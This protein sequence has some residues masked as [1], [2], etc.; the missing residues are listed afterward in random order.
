MRVG[1]RVANQ[2]H[3][4]IP[5][6]THKHGEKANSTSKRK[7]TIPPRSAIDGSS[8]PS[9]WLTQ[10]RTCALV[11][12]GR[13]ASATTPA[14]RT[15][16]KSSSAILSKFASHLSQTRT[17]KADNDT[18]SAPRDGH[19]TS[20]APNS[21]RNGNGRESR[22]QQQSAK[23]M[24]SGR[25]SHK[26]RT[27]LRMWAGTCGFGSS[28]SD[29]SSARSS[30]RHVIAV[31]RE[32]HQD[33]KTREERSIHRKSML[34]EVCCSNGNDAQR[35]QHA[36]TTKPDTTRMTTSVLKKVQRLSNAPGGF[37]CHLPT[38]WIAP[39][40]LLRTRASNTE[41]MAAN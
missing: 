13:R 17:T 22:R 28:A 9:D 27:A 16:A 38:R 4:Q 34:G 40:L 23:R 41:T 12:R 6:K 33:S 7:H 5:A 18:Q 39:Q 25:K 15:S 32:K 11:A 8:K 1:A 19:V 37:L 10:G 31:A 29:S 14:R 30:G 35:T 36:G 26:R 2:R 21:S 24:R 3:Q 20:P